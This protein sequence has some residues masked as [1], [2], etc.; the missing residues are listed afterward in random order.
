MRRATRR[1]LERAGHHVVDVGDGIEAIAVVEDGFDPTVVLTDVVLPGS[2]NG[3]DLASRIL[4]MTPTARVVFASGYPSEIITRR[5]LL[6][7]GAQ[8]I[9]KPFSSETLLD[10]IRGEHGERIGVRA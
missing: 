5:Q 2:L 10:A 9:A 1:L 6:D 4:Q 7:E 8:F 3:R